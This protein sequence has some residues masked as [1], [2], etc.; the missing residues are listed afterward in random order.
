[1]EN[2]TN[3]TSSGGV[4]LPILF[5]F[6]VMGFVDVVGI[7]TNY[8]KQDFALS[9]TLANLIPMMVFLWFAVFSIPTALL[10]GR[11]GRRNTVAWALVVTI[12]TML[13]PLCC[14]DFGVVLVAFAL[15]GIGNTMLQVSLNPMVAAVVAP[16][17]ITS[18]LTLGQFI[19]A[20]S[21]LLGPVIAGAVA[22]LWGDWKWIFAVYA[23]TTLLSL[24]W[25]LL[26]V[27]ADSK[28][29]TQRTGFRTVC[30]LFRDRYILMLFL[31]ILFIV[32]VDVGLNTTIPKL[33][34]EK[35]DMPLD[36]AGL[37]TSLYFLARTVGSFIGAFVLARVASD[38]FL[39]YSMIVSVVAF[40]ALL[41][42]DS[43]WPMAAMIVIVGL[44]CAN[45]FSILFAFALQHMPERDNEISALMIMGV[46]GGALITPVMGVLADAFGQVAAL[47]LLLVCMA[48]LGVI[49]LKVKK[50]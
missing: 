36:D 50:H 5:G 21:S 2:N 33:L 45:V 29:D 4:I 20:I 30:S 7:A 24:L 23:V 47:S 26:V 16:K 46:S 27:P 34:M 28:P 37:G 8:V 44:A 43:L 14:Y 35:L 9:D 6:F 17:R 48:Y 12:G 41:T 31:G 49:A 42:L 1:M 15:L 38:R 22:A 3:K 19:K 25:L 13:L 10:M 39:L 40:I 18:V 32:G 11:I